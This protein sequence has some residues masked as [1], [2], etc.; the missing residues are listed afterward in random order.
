[1]RWPFFRKEKRQSQ[2]PLNYGAGNW[3]PWGFR[4]NAFAYNA[5]GT[6]ALSVPGVALV[7]RVY[8][9]CLC[10]SKIQVLN[11]E[12]EPVDHPLLGVFEEPA[13]GFPLT[14]EGWLAHM[15]TSIILTGSFRARIQS[16][17]SGTIT[18]L[19]PFSPGQIYAYARKGER[20]TLER[21]I[22]SG[23]VFRDNRGNVWPASKI[24]NIL[25]QVFVSWDWLNPASR[26]AMSE[27]ILRRAIDLSESLSGMTESGMI[28]AQVISGNW[29][30]PADKRKEFNKA[31][32]QFFQGGATKRRRYL[33][34]PQDM[35]MAPIPGMRKAA[36]LWP[37]IMFWSLQS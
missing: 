7:C 3:L 6:A 2:S 25:D 21:A 20:A 33:W 36:S 37:F 11:R 16:D 31:L 35:K 4:D 13:P 17:S 28:P 29:D 19:Y 9:D 14:R 32:E 18:A 27:G 15:V 5:A 23:Y 12:K 8:S 24:L 34:L 30:F 26:L 10:R 1:M 22:K